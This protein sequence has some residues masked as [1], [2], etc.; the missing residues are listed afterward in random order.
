[1]QHMPSTAIYFVAS[2]TIKAFT[3]W[4]TQARAS[5]VNMRYVCRF[6][7]SDSCKSLNSSARH[8]VLATSP[9]SGMRSVNSMVCWLH[10]S[11][12][13]HR[14]RKDKPEKK[15]EVEDRTAHKKKEIIIKIKRTKTHLESNLRLPSILRTLRLPNPQQ[16]HNPMPLPPHH[17][18]GS[19]VMPQ[20]LV[21]LFFG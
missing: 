2:T 13:Q 9:V 7:C 18:I 6:F 8:V 10:C 1:M 15:V 21:S 4:Y 14:R 17:P 11:V 20:N 5:I 3:P 16:L 12:R 19:L